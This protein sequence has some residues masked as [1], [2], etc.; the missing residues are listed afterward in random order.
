MSRNKKILPRKKS[1]FSFVVDGECEFWYLQMMKDNEKSLN[2]NLLPEIYKKK[3]LEEQYQRV[4]ELAKES[5]KVFWIID[6]DVINKETKEVKQ[7]QKNKLTKF[8]EYY[9]KIKRHS[10]VE[11]IINN[12]C[13]EFWILLHFCYTNRFYENYKKLLPDL[14]KYL[15]DYDKTEK[16]FMKSIPDIYKRLKPNLQTAITNAQKSGNF[17]FENPETGVAEMY[18]LF[19]EDNLN[20]KT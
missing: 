6:F 2:I 8:K 13:F 9:L 14:Q 10:N 1:I 4:I 11:V 15:S 17:D 7:G 19:T 12:P 3:T 16:Y 20:L 18:K 5:K